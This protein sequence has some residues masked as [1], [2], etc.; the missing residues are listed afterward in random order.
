M[1]MLCI[2][3]SRSGIN[4]FPGIVYISSFRI[5]VNILIGN[6][7]SSIVHILQFI[8]KYSQ[9]IKILLQVDRFKF[10]KSEYHRFQWKC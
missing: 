5:N 7:K 2:N 9:V 1:Y 10:I 4:R 3:C 8:T 6:F